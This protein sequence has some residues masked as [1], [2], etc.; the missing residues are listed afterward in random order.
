VQALH[1][2]YFQLN[3]SYKTVV[4]DITYFVLLSRDSSKS[5]VVQQYRKKMCYA[6]S[7]VLLP[8]DETRVNI[9]ILLDAVHVLR[10]CL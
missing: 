9:R 5:D 4:C 6:L 7:N 10:N 8:S 3:T 1:C 2:S